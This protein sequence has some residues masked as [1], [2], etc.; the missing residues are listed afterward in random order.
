MAL[1]TQDGDALGGMVYTRLFR[2]NYK[3]LQPAC[4]NTATVL[5]L[6]EN[7]TNLRQHT[8]N[9]GTQ[10]IAVQLLPRQI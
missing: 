5:L 1:R 9:S 6:F 10:R 7:T 4:F 3:V 2:T 8:A